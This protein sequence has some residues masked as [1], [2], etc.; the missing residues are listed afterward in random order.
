MNKYSELLE[1]EFFDFASHNKAIHAGLERP[2]RGVDEPRLRT[3]TDDTARF[4]SIKKSQP[5]YDEYLHIRYYAV[6]DSCVNAAIGEVMNAMS[7]LTPLSPEHAA[8]AAII[9]G[10]TRTHAATEEACRTRLGFFRPTKGGQ[11][12]SDSDRASAELDCPRAFLPITSYRGLRHIGR[13]TTSVRGPD[14]RS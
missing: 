2:P 8:C 3:L 1:H 5:V 11:T 4:P 10:G 12:S 13:A 6:F 9:L 7:T 14:S